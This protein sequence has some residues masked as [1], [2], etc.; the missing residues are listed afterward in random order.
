MTTV[1]D[2]HRLRDLFEVRRGPVADALVDVVG[3]PRSAVED[4]L[5]EAGLD[6]LVPAAAVTDA[7]IGR[8][9]GSLVAV[10]EPRRTG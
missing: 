3:I 10:P 2:V 4:V 6:P 8:L 7:E 1:P 9:R 5:A